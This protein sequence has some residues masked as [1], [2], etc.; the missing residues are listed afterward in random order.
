MSRRAI[1]LLLLAAGCGSKPL[2]ATPPHPELPPHVDL[3]TGRGVPIGAGEAF[4]I[5]SLAIA[6]QIV[7][8]NALFQGGQYMNDQLRQGLL[9]GQALFIVEIAGIDAPYYGDDDGIELR[10]YGAQDADDPFFPANNFQIPAG[11]TSCCTFN[12]L[13]LDPMTGGAPTRGISAKVSGYRLHSDEDQPSIRV[14][15][16]LGAPPY[17]TLELALPDIEVRAP[18]GGNVLSDGVMRGAWTIASL[19]PIHNPFCGI[20]DAIQDG[21]KLAT[22]EM[23]LLDYLVDIGGNQ[24]DVDLDGDGLERFEMRNR[25]VGRCFDGD[26]TE[27]VS[28]DPEAPWLCAEDPRMADGFSIALT[29]SGVRARIEAIVAP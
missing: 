16:H 1:F 8:R 6:D 15:L 11:E 22:A 3:T 5:D 4:V 29:F 23:S 25:Q 10:F 2:P 13:P 28:R 19:S 21:C 14:P 20:E 12:V 7:A 26:G 18:S 27:V 9:G 24:P 17:H